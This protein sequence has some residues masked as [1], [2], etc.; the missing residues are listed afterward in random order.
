M[1]MLQSQHRSSIY[2]RQRQRICTSYFSAKIA[3]FFSKYFPINEIYFLYRSGHYSRNHCLHEF[4]YI[5]DIAACTDTFS[6]YV[7]AE[8]TCDDITC[9]VQNCDC[10]VLCFCT[11]MRI[12]KWINNDV[13]TT[14]AFV[15][16]HVLCAFFKPFK[17][18]MDRFFYT[19]RFPICGQKRFNSFILLLTLPVHC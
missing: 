9:C 7:L 5:L 14:A 8:A 6:R 2:W 19:F 3:R 17:Q 15:I 12:N 18:H 13:R 11:L 10:V 16:F 1:I 4:G